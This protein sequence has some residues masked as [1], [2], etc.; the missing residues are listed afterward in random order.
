MRKLRHGEV[1]Q[2]AHSHTARK[3]ELWGLNSGTWVMRRVEEGRGEAPSRGLRATA[4][5]TFLFLL[6]LLHKYIFHQN[7]QSNIFILT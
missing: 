3:D 4:S 5:L 1:K 6:L 7:L 2:L